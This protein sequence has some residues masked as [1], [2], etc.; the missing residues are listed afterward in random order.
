[1][2]ARHELEK[3]RLSIEDELRTYSK[4]GIKN[5]NRHH[6]RLALRLVDKHDRLEAELAKLPPFEP[7]PAFDVVFVRPSLWQR[8]KRWVRRCAS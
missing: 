4:I 1:M 6:R 7:R 2:T 5:L 3:Q 8:F